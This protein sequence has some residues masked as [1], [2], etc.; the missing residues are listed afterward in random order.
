MAGFPKDLTALVELA[1]GTSLE[2]AA[3]DEDKLER[4]LLRE[5]AASDDP[6]AKEIGSGLSDGTMSWRMLATGGVYADFVNQGLAALREFDFDQA[7]QVLAEEKAESQR[8][9]AARRES[10][11][12]DDLDPLWQGF[13]R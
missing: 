8:V 12:R 13:G 6:I 10:D 2:H 4:L 3:G 11:E 1:K 9:D 7:A 5:M